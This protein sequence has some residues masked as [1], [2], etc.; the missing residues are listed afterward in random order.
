MTDRTPLATTGDLADLL[1][2]ELVGPRDLPIFGVSGLDEAGPGELSF[3]RSPRYAG[4]WADS[5]AVAAVVTR[6][7]EVSGHDDTKRALIYVDDADRAMIAMLQ[8]AQERAPREIPEPGVHPGAHIGE[9]ASV[10]A[11]ASVGPGAVIGRGA[12]IGEGAVIGAH[13]V[14]AAGVSV[15]ARTVLHPQVTL[16]SQTSVGDD[17]EIFPC[18]VV[19]TDGF[20]YLPGPE[21]P[22]KVPHLG[23][24]T[25]GSRVEIGAGTTIDRGKFG[26]TVI[27]DATKI[28]N[29]VQIAHACQIG[30]GVI[31]CGCSALGG[32]V[33]IGD[34]A[35][36]AGRVSVRDNVAI[37]PG[38][39][40]GGNSAVDGDVDASEPWFGYPA[41]P[42]SVAR[43][44]YAATQ[45]LGDI[46]RTM[47]DLAKRVGA[48]EAGRAAADPDRVASGDA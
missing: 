44:N 43:R 29:Q 36:L 13:C 48:I 30:R 38:A 12:T 37:A 19:G 33:T 2:A 5:R 41:R 21:G 6:G 23:G 7:I 18:V 22:V 27:G 31:I 39:I 47:R 16:L 42:L 26:D 1:G 40:V 25:I 20:G 11:S 32:S 14:L 9:G 8:A 24:V 4:R 15:G 3:I 34:G 28:D 35:V 17:C 45:K 46:W 10:P